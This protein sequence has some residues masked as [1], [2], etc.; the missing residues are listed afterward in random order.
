MQELVEEAVALDGGDPLAGWRAEFVIADPELAY[1]DGNSLGMPTKRAFERVEQVMRDDWAA[2]LIRSWDQWLDWPQAVGAELAPLIGAE[3]NEVVVHDSTSVN[4]F[5]LITAAV[6]LR[7]DRRVIAVDPT[8]FPTDRYIVESIA[9][10]CGMEVRAGFDQL[11]DVAVAVRSMVDYRSAEIVDVA[12]EATRAC[13]AGAVVVWDLSHAAGL[14]PVR[15]HEVGIDLAVGC[16]YKFLNGGPGAPA[17]TFVRADLIEQL[18]E[19]FHGWFAQTDQFAMGDTFTPRADIG[20]FRIGT[21]SIL[22]LVAAQA[23][24]EVSAAAGIEAIRAK[25]VELGRFGL[26]CCDALGLSTSTPRDDDRRGGHLCVHEP[27]A[28]RIVAEMTEH[29]RVLADFR[30]PDVVRL[31][32]SPLTTRFADVARATIAVADRR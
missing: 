14:L 3:P 8:D 6:D 31:G 4:L 29:D 16:T 1:L 22:S 15:V 5:Q 23:G 28:R 19:P 10:A 26:R 11:D 27:D 25:S 20:R 17:F 18:D 2:G 32:C 21:P 30:E 13:E 12:T 24:I 7:P 9:A